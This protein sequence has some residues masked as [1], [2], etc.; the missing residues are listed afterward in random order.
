MIRIGKPYLEEKSG[1]HWINCIIHENGQAK[2]VVWG[3]V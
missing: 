2:K 3:G 1:M